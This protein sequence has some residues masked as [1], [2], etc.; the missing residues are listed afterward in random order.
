MR[1][2]HIPVFQERRTNE[3]VVLALEALHE[4]ELVF[5]HV[6][7][8]LLVVQ[9]VH[10]D[11]D[12]RARLD[13]EHTRPREAR[14]VTIKLRAHHK[15]VRLVRAGGK[16][17][18]ESRSCTLGAH[19]CEPVGLPHRLRITLFGCRRLRT[20]EFVELRRRFSQ[21]VLEKGALCAGL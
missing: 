17:A 9:D 15:F 4:P 16:S 6:S 8:V 19:L 1:G 20:P 2:G 7:R 21:K 18:L 13:V 3:I 11:G 5:D 14:V 10:A 12:R